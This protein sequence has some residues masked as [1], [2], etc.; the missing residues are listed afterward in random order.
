MLMNFNASLSSWQQTFSR[1]R[2]LYP[3]TLACLPANRDA[4]VVHVLHNTHLILLIPDT[5]S[6]HLS[7]KSPLN[8]PPVAYRGRYHVCLAGYRAFRWRNVCLFH[9]RS[10]PHRNMPVQNI[11]CSQLG[12]HAKPEPVCSA[13]SDSLSRR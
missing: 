8:F 4:F 3:G 5:R 6:L 7:V 12:I 1:I 13:C 2:N 11:S 9:L 10:R